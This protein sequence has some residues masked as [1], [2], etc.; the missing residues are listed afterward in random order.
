KQVLEYSAAFVQKYR[1]EARYLERTAP[2]VERVGLQYIKDALFDEKQR[3]A[4]AER[5]LH[6]QTFS[7]I[8][9]WKARAEGEEAHEFRKIKIC[10]A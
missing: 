2:W 10:A 5:F 6:S 7:Q 4:L 3:K 1:E 9:P 8:D